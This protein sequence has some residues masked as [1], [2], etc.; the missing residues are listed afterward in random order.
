GLAASGFPDAEPGK[1][2]GLTPLALLE[3]HVRGD[4]PSA[5]RSC[6]DSLLDVPTYAKALHRRATSNDAIGTWPSLSAAEKLISVLTKLPNYQIIRQ[7]PPSPSLFP[8]S[9]RSALR[10]SKL[11]GL[12]RFGMS[13][14]NFQLTAN[15][16][17]GYS[18]NFLN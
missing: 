5:V 12:G 1:M 15:G 13:I 11:K 4:H 14:N 6:T 17:G 9:I 8:P 10:I 16:Q 3:Q 2:G 7:T 18:M